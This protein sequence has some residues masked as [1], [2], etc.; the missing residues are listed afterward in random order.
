MRVALMTHSDIDNYGDTW[1][2]LICRAELLQRIPDAEISFF[3]CTGTVVEETSFTAYDRNLL[4]GCFDG[5]L[6]TGGEVVHAEDEMLRSIYRRLRRIPRVQDPTDIVYDWADIRTGYKAWLGVGVPQVTAESAARI[7]AAVPHLDRIALRGALSRANL[8][9]AVGQPM[10]CRVGPDLGWAIPRHVANHRA[11]LR[12]VARMSG[13]SLESEPY[14]VFHTMDVCLSGGAAGISD[15]AAQLLTIQAE[16]GVRIVLL[17]I[18]RC[19]E[20]WKCLGDL[21]RDSRGGLIALPATLTV[22]ETAAVIMNASAFVGS[23]L[24]GAL[25]SLAAGI[26]AGLIYPLSETK[27]TEL[28]AAHHRAYALIRSWEHLPA[29]VN[30]LLTEPREP[31]RLQARLMRDQVATLFDI[32]AAEM[33]LAAGAPSLPTSPQNALLVAQNGSLTRQNEELVAEH[34]ALIA[35]QREML[36]HMGSFARQTD[37]LLAQNQLLLRENQMLAPENRALAEDNRQLGG[38]VA[39]SEA[40]AATLASEN[41][42][43]VAQSTALSGQYQALLAEVEFLRFHYHRKISLAGRELAKLVGRVPLV[44][45]VATTAALPVAKGVW[46]VMK[47]R[48]A[49]AARQ[50]QLIAVQAATSEAIAAELPTRENTVQ[51]ML[52]AFAKADPPSWVER[53]RWYSAED[54][55]VSIIILNLNKADLTIRCM[56]ELWKHTVGRRYEIIVV[57]NGSHA[58]DF[59]KLTRFQGKYRL[60]RLSRNRYFGEGNN[61]GAESGKGKYLLFLNNDAFVTHGWIQPFMRVFEEHRD[62]GA[63]GPMFLY[64]DGTLQEAG[65]LVN[66]DGTANMLG[67]NGEADDPKFNQLREVDYCS[68]AGLMVRKD[69]F[70]EV[71]GFDLCWEPAYYEDVDLCMK[72][73]Q[74]GYG[75]FYCPETKIVHIEHF[76][77]LDSSHNIFFGNVVE[78]NRHKFVARWREHL[79]EQGTVFADVAAP[80]L[81][82]GNRGGQDSTWRRTV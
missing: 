17:P 81:A 13:I 24:H 28:F 57:D 34:Q 47:Q 70:D 40:Q 53:D 46:H 78:I 21:S 72:I 35:Q 67:R 75:V 54:P 69:L 9:A 68:A 66:G 44:R 63:V 30:G 59:V 22:R 79:S 12:Q 25:T 1:F 2:P 77:S 38:R 80:V 62:A 56:K 3:S 64:P 42:A 73:K 36:A 19:W 26:P 10:A 52:Q 60:I 29:L 39:E 11:L 5:V 6:L 14:I 37:D 7:R 45:R 51:Q 31:L 32:T 55:E 50:R 76:T 41:A 43:L 71:L 23:S 18:T 27:F 48:R 61:I 49:D 20:D 65:S 4:D 82:A 58:D 16:T 74:L 8:D 15:L 33:R